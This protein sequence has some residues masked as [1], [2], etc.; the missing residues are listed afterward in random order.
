MSSMLSI[1]K[2]AHLMDLNEADFI[3]VSQQDIPLIQTYLSKA[4][5][6]ESNHNIVNFFQWIKQYPLWKYATEHYLLLLGI[7]KGKLFSYM[8]LCEPQYFEEAILKDKLIFSQFNIPFELSCFTEKEKDKVLALL[9]MA[10]VTCEEEA[11]DYIYEADKLR[12]LSGGKLQKRR[13]HYNAFLRNTEGHV[14]TEEITAQ[15]K[16]E[17]KA[18]LAS[19]KTDANDEYFLYE[20]EGVFSILDL[21]GQLPCRGLLLRIDGE[22]KAFLI[23][24][25]SSDRMVQINI[26]K[27]DPSIRGLYQAIE[28]EYL[29]TFYTEALL[30]NREDDMG[31]E[32][33]RQAK[34][35]LDPL[36]MI[37]KYRLREHE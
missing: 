31:L 16:D 27:A 32:S 28:V 19:W 20:K 1:Q 13:N 14:F 37:H 34:R 36:M 30:V 29:K 33:L 12:T 6:E 17:V 21:M 4:N 25:K 22:V 8:P 26:E 7:H 2:E 24:T 10:Y 15:N 18:F 5:Y 23:G 11:S 9:P 3:P 35:A